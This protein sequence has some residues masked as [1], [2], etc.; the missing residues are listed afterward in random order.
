MSLKEYY[1]KK[2][3][4]ILFFLTLFSLIVIWLSMVYYIGAREIIEAIGLENVYL[5]IFIIAILSGSSSFVSASFFAIYISIASG[6]DSYFLLSVFG[7][8]GLSVGDS[9]FYYLGTRGRKIDG[10]KW[11]KMLTKLSSWVKKQSLFLIYIIIFIYNAFTPL[12][13]DILNISLGLSGI[14]YKKVIPII[15]LGNIALLYIVAYFIGKN[16]LIV[17]FF[18]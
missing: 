15:I 16:S 4:N 2:Y 13:G 1:G 5:L 7:G 8:L 3:L 11:Q 6:L 9:I 14:N 10:K 17:N 12:P 18:S